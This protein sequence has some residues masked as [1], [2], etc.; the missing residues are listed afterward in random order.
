MKAKFDELLP[1]YN[2]YHQLYTDGSKQDEVASFGL[3]CELGDI[4]K[5]IL[6][7][8]S[9]FTAELE[10][11]QQALRAIDVSTLKK[12]VVFCDSKSVLE[13]IDN[14]NTDNPIVVQV[15]D[16]IQSI[17]SHKIVKFCWIL[18]F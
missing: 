8:S 9:I 16:H 17:P 2:G 1:Q 11:I 7:G 6:D 12:F 10:G 14:Y 15:L 3:H 4:S 18:M 5:R 13:S